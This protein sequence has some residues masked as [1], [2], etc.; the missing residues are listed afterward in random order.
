M[1]RL[2]EAV[3][4]KLNEL[5]A[6]MHSA[7]DDLKIAGAE[8]NLIGDFLEVQA[9]NDAC[10][11]LQAL[12]S[13]F[14]STLNHFE[15]NYRASAKG[16]ASPRK[17][18]YTRKPGGRIRVKL[19]NQSIEEKT[20][21]ETFIKTLQ[22]LGLDRVARLNKVVASIPLIAKTPTNGYQSQQRC[23]GWYITT[24]V[25]QQTAITVLEDIG[26]ALNVPIKV[27]AIER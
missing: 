23:D 20:I 26:K 27:E 2:P 18:Q 12:D 8:A 17:P 16:K 22:L 11:K 9:I 7:T 14:K 25:N 6:V 24:H 1:K 10:R 3:T 19:A 4:T 13:E 5:F 21:R 15:A